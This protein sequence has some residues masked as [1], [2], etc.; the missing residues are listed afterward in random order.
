MNSISL[1]VLGFI[2]IIMIEITKNEYCSGEKE[3]EDV[4]GVCSI[5][6]AE[7]QNKFLTELEDILDELLTITISDFRKV[8]TSLELHNGKGANGVLE[9][10]NEMS[11]HE[12]DS[13]NCI[14]IA[15]KFKE[16]NQSSINSLP[17]AIFGNV[18]FTWVKTSATLMRE[19]L[20]ARI[21]DKLNSCYILEERS[22]V[23]PALQR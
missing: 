16:F 7:K 19:V 11:Y 10:N 3:I 9:L 1:I 17:G 22:G 6:E 14:Y 4:T 13:E 2:M 21:D 12:K 5:A 23:V 8:L 15:T 18:D 20:D